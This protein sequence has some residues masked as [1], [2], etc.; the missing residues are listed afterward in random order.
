MKKNIKKLFLFIIIIIFLVFAYSSNVFALT[1]QTSY[2]NINSIQNLEVE[3]LLFTNISFKDYSSTSTQAFGLSGIVKNSSNNEVNY[4]ATVYYYDSAYNLIAKRTNSTTAK[5]G[6]NSFNQMSNLTILN[7]HKV[8]EI[9]CYSL[10]IEITDYTNSSNITPSQDYQYKTRDYVIDKYDINIIVNENNTFDITETIT[11][12]FNVPKHGIIRSIPLKNNI[13]RLDGTKST[14]RTQ[15]TNISVDNEYTTSKENGFYKLKIGKANHTLTKE[16]TYIIKYRYNLGKD[17]IKDYDELYYNIIGNEWDTVIGNITFSITMPKDFD[18]SKLGFS[19][20][21]KGSTDNTK[22]QYSVNGNQITGSYNGILDAGEAL[23]IRCELPE[24]YFVGASYTLTPLMYIMFIIPILGL[25]IT[26]ILWYKF[27]RDENVIETIEF[28]PPEGLNS[29]DVG[30]LYKGKAENKDVTS[31]LIYLANKGYL[32]ICTDKIATEQNNDIKINSSDISKN[33]INEKIVELQ[34]KI[35]DEKIIN[36]NSQKIKYYENML[37]IYKE[38]N[39]DIDY[40]QAPNISNKILNKKNKFLIRKLKDYDGTNACEQWFMEGLFAFGRTEVTDKMLYNNFYTINNRILYNVN[41]KQNKDK[42][43][44]KNTLGKSI[45]V[46][47]LMIISILTIIVVPTVEYAGVEEL[48]TTL[49]LWAFY[50]PFFA[51][52]IFAKLPLLFR[53]LW[54]GFTSFHSLFIFNSLPI[55]DAI[56]NDKIYFFGFIFGIICLIGMAIFLK[57]MPKRTEYGNEMLGKLKGFKN[58][59]ETVEKQKLESMVLENPNYFYDILPFT[60]V[61]GVSDKWIK[62]FES[63]S[64]QA[65]AWYNS[66][67][68]FNISNFSTFVNST[69]SSAQIVMSSRPSSSSSGSSGHSSGSFSGGSSGGGFSG[70]GSGG[71]GGSSW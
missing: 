50:L 36:S 10:S 8:S 9:Y 41:D 1:E 12:Y 5:S 59:L 71:G 2:V 22:I 39:K 40:E 31:L 43:F 44:E 20:G 46:G 65:P 55:A 26:F 51:V 32:E 64:L 38:M 54:L 47:I 3:N 28:Y 45:I 25:I 68:A 70:G 53:I 62:K 56:T 15:I 57:L 17:Q 34:N 13:T 18:S 4:I 33:R 14:N 60:Y 69:M 21:S 24:G 37:D 49:V 16:Q 48:G 42:I 66:S 7:G 11:T 58:F 61:L 67:N 30:F 29:L 6:T 27:G 63:I 52:G 23:T 19:S 35:A